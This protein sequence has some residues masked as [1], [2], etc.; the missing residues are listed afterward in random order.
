MAF[1][2]IVKQMY[3]KNSPMPA[4]S[5]FTPLQETSRMIDS[6]NK[7][8]CIAKTKKQISKMGITC[9]SI[10]NSIGSVPRRI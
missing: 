4:C 8:C 6:G 2:Q 7:A 9:S 10:W 5:S 3:D 1:R